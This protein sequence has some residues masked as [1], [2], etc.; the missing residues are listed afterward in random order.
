MEIPYVVTFIVIQS[1]MLDSNY[2][3]LLSHPWLRNA[4]V[5]YDWGNN[6]ITIQGISTF[7]TIHVIKKL[8]TPTKHLEVLVY[9]DFHFGISYEEEDLMFAIEP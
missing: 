8:G 5:S 6:T 3:M 9:Y 7:K 1:S 2:S 4:K